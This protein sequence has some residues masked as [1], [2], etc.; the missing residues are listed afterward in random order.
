MNKMIGFKKCLVASSLMVMLVACGD[1]AQK[2]Q[3]QS[4]DGLLSTELVSNPRSA[5]GLD[6][7]AYNEL[8]TMDFE[9]SVHDFGLLTEGMKA[10]HAFEFV[11]NGKTPLIVSA[12]KG[13]CGCAVAE[14]PRDPIAPGASGIIQVVFDTYGKNGHQEKSIAITTNSKR[15]TEML[16]IKADVKAAQ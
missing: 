3:S 11:N 10:T 16:Y 14:Y 2:E 6:T 1:N 8:P 12:A 7:A 4:K 13:S 9:D 5:K 15:G